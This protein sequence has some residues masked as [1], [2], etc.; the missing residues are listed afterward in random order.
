MSLRSTSLRLSSTLIFTLV[1]L[2]AT[3]TEAGAVVQTINN[4]NQQDQ[5]ITGDSN[6]TFNTNT[7][8]GQHTIGWNGLLPISRGGTG[9][10]SFT[11][12][13]IPFIS[14][15]V[16]SQDNSNF[17]WDNTN[18]RLGIG[19]SSPSAALEVVSG[20]FV[21]TNSVSPFTGDHDIIFGGGQTNTGHIYGQNAPNGSLRDGSTIH[22]QAGV[23]DSSIRG[24]HVRV[25]GG[26]GGS[27]G[28]QGGDVVIQGGTAGGTN[29]NGG[30]LEFRAGLK[31]GTG[32]YGEYKFYDPTQTYA[33]IFN[34]S[35]LTSTNRTYSFPNTAGTFGLLESDQTWSGLNK[36][37]DNT[38]TTLYVG[39]SSLTGCIALGDSD[40][41][42]VTYI[43]ANDGVLSA[44]STKPSTCQ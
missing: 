17:S 41:S 44:S 5:T 1:F 42:G 26:S 31:N 38:N 19:T 16:F 4:A 12:G 3:P 21:L 9:A 27:S 10:S 8:N 36:I 28:G 34:F 39:S 24:G 22:I 7:S 37:E 18:K 15:G 40:S 20:N 25:V 14:G 35:S 23:G 43:T 6:V 13:S 11:N 29:A 2:L 33:G 32:S 30:N